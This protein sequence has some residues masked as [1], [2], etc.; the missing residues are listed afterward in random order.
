[1]GAK[2][3]IVGRSLYGTCGMSGIDIFIPY[4]NY[5]VWP[6]GTLWFCLKTT[7]LDG[8]G[9]PH[10]L[11]VVQ[12][13]STNTLLCLGELGAVGI[14]RELPYTCL[15]IL[16]DDIC[17]NGYHDF[18][19]LKPIY[20]ECPVLCYIRNSLGKIACGLMWFGRSFLWASCHFCLIF[21]AGDQ[22]WNL[23]EAGKYSTQ[24]AYYFSIFVF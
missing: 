14:H 5:S 11:P 2:D 12:V 13:N 19:Y 10:S 21:L 17:R 22:T 23:S 20:S 4:C 8:L 7:W 24:P 3:Q 18:L 16:Q 6:G 1:M 15:K 9:T